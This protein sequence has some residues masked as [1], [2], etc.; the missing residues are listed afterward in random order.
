VGS[1]SGPTGPLRGPDGPTSVARRAHFCGPTGSLL[2][3]SG[4]AHRGLKGPVHRA[5]PPHLSLGPMG[6]L[7]GLRRAHFGAQRAYST[8]GA[9]RAWFVVLP[10]VPSLCSREKHEEVRRQ[11]DLNSATVMEDTEM[12]GT[13]TGRLGRSSRRAHFWAR[14]AHFQTRRAHF[15]ARRAHFQARRARSRFP[16]IGEA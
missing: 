9:R 12:A 6:P 5:L 1:L 4:L 11:V 2:G 16:G 15:E 14:R 8:V 7:L 3:P 13:D 10:L